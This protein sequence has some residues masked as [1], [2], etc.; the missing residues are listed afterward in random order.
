V[1]IAAAKALHLKSRA[2]VAEGKLEEAQKLEEKRVTPAC[3]AL[4]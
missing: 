2:L 3:H 1:A 4:E